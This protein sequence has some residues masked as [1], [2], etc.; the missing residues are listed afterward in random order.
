MTLPNATHSL[1]RHTTG[2][3]QTSED[4]EQDAHLD[5][6][7]PRDGVLATIY[8]KL[9]KGSIPFLRPWVSKAD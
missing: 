2:R 7:E 5:T 8:R 1:S 3:L 6:Q 4:V 9:S